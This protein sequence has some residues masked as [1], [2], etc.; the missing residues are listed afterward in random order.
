MGVGNAGREEGREG[1]R[2]MGRE[3]DGVKDNVG[4]YGAGTLGLL[5]LWISG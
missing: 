5:K 1:G 4:K 3:G 2:E